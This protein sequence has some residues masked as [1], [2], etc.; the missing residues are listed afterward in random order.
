MR[1]LLD[2]MRHRKG[3]LTSLQFARPGAHG[4]AP[5]ARLFVLVDG[6]RDGVGMADRARCTRDHYVDLGFHGFA[7]V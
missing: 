7:V 1:V 2:G 3:G 4:S 5:L 6:D